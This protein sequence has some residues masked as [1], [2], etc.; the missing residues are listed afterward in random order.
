MCFYIILFAE[1]S[2]PVFVKIFLFE[3]S[4]KAKVIGYNFP[5][6]IFTI[7]LQFIVVVVVVGKFACKFI[8]LY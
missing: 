7:Y 2:L 6:I 5:F 1:N 4:T 3:A 8:F